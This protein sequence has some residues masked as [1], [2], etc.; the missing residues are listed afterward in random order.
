MTYPSGET[1]SYEYSDRTGLP[2]SLDSD[3]GDVIV[4]SASYAARGR[5]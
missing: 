3:Q 5:A 1:V 2:T 4:A